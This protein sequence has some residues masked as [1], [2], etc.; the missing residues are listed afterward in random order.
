MCVAYVRSRVCVCVYVYVSLRVYVHLYVCS[1]ACGMYVCMRACIYV[2]AYVCLCMYVCAH[3]GEID[4]RLDAA[5][6]AQGIASAMVWP[7]GASDL[8]CEAFMCMCALHCTAKR[9]ILQD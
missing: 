8:I 3:V 7:C 2:Y 1:C 5:H 4:L 9:K 6:V